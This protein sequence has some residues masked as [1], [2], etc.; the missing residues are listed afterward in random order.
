[1]I[2]VSIWYSSEEAA[3]AE[4]KYNISS[5]PDEGFWAEGYI[6]FNC[7]CSILPTY[8]ALNGTDK[9]CIILLKNG[10]EFTINLSSDEAVQLKEEASRRYKDNLTQVQ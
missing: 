5:D 10:Y 9:S 2:K 8:N 3:E 4:R 6:D 1:M 7:I